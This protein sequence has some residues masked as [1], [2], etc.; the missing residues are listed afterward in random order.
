MPGPRFTN[1]DSTGVCKCRISDG[2]VSDGFH[3][4]V[5][6]TDFAGAALSIMNETTYDGGRFKPTFGLIKQGCTRRGISAQILDD[7]QC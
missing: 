7:Q 2:G 6:M 3:A 1:S 5:K 4:A